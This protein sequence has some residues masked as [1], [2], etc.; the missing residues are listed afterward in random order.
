MR[1]P[2]NLIR[3]QSLLFEYSFYY[4]YYFCYEIQIV[5]RNCELSDIYVVFGAVS[6]GSGG[7]L[8]RS[9]VYGLHSGLKTVLDAIDVRI[10]HIFIRIHGD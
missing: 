9:I 5:Y 10:L 8:H 2:D 1:K 7:Q 6:D 3:T 4:T